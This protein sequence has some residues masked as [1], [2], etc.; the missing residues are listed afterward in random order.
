MVIRLVIQYIL[1]AKYYL[2]D[3]ISSWLYPDGIIEIIYYHDGIQ[4]NIDIED[5]ETIINKYLILP[6][7]R[8]EFVYRHNK[9]IYRKIITYEKRVCNR[10]GQREILSATA[11]G[12]DITRKI[13]E[14][15][16]PNNDFHL[17][18]GCDIKKE[19]ICGNQDLIIIDDELNEHIIRTGEYLRER[20]LSAPSDALVS[21]LETPVLDQ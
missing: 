9:Q 18:Q 1:L 19:W 13:R 15:M 8:L 3:I 14:F 10:H 11:D 4:I 21:E 7:S 5:E 12:N 6:N 2:T 17:G 20:L 16:G